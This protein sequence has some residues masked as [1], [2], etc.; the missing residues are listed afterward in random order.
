MS[1]RIVQDIESQVLADFFL[2]LL[3]YFGLVGE[4]GPSFDGCGHLINDHFGPT[5]FH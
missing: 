4:L 5:T 1:W 3:V 2:M